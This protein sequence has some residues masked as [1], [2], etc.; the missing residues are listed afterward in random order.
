MFMHGQ[1]YICHYPDMTELIL[2]NAVR[3]EQTRGQDACL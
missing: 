3:Q 1:D 2:K